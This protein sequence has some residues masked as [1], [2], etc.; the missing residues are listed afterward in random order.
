MRRSSRL[1]VSFTT[2]SLVPVVLLGVMLA[3]GYADD[4]VAE[5]L[6]RGRVQAALIQDMVISPA[7][8]TDDLVFGADER[9]RV[10]TA[11][12]AAVFHGSVARL[13]LRDPAGRVVVSDD[14]SAR[15]VA[16]ADTAGLAAAM[17]G[18]TRI[19][20]VEDPVD[21]DGAPGMIWVV[22]P[23]RSIAGDKVIGVLELYLPY[24]AVVAQAKARLQQ[25]YWRLGPGL[26]G[27]YLVLVAIAWST[28]RRLR[29]HAQQHEHDS[30]HDPLT[31]LANRKLF[32]QRA[33]Q[34]RGQAALGVP[35]AIVLVDLDYFK[36]VNDSFGHHTGDALLRVVAERLSATLRGSD[37]VARLGGDE[38]G[39]VLPDIADEEAVMRLAER[40]RAR[41]TKPVQVGAHTLPVH[42]SFGIALYPRHG[43]SVEVLLRCADA[44]MYRAKRGGIV[45]Y[46][47]EDEA[48][49]AL[50][51]TGQTNQ[52]SQAGQ[53]RQTGQ[54][55]RPA[56]TPAEMDQV[57][58]R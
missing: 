31:G 16:P 58:T 33:E 52:T 36:Q 15:T 46:D 57:V 35:G 45:M 25:A 3:R 2:A 12:R 48:Q 20:I 7:V 30:L 10:R 9:Q 51:Q 17:G 24:D 39:L 38:F 4:A 50:S 47:P 11:I 18:D 8:R 32:M 14:D 53:T 22:Q 42:A 27:L 41:L 55:E 40:I 6:Q 44:A 54:I 43:E 5:G 23:V 13:L 29:R 1:F 26:V 49:T 37:T 19:S 34:A 28:T 21:G 56:G